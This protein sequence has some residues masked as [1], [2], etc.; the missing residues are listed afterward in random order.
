M[1][2]WYNALRLL[3][4]WVREEMGEDGQASGR[5]CEAGTRVV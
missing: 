4:G 5:A 2:L 3:E 1:P